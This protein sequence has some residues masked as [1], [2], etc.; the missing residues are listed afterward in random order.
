MTDRNKGID[1]SLHGIQGPM[2]RSDFFERWWP[3]TQSLDLVKGSMKQVAEAVDATVSRFV[4]A[5]PL[6]KGWSRYA[7]LD[8]AFSA[9][10]EF[11]GVPT[12]FLLLPTHSD[13]VVLWTNSFLCDGYD[14]LCHLLTENYGLTTM[15]WSAHDSTTTFQPATTFTHRA[16]AQSGLVER[17]VYASQVDGKWIFGEIGAALPE[18]DVER[19]TARKK[20]DR[21]NESLMVDLLGRMGAEPWKE[22]YY[23]LPQQE[24]WTL[25]R[26]AA[27][28]TVTRRPLASVVGATCE[29]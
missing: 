7:D 25:K 6:E 9:A 21:L 3:A 19:Y 8:Q 2:L 16:M 20:A 5:E 11:A 17:S 14:S 1:N 26:V 27:P 28:K 23:A 13:W 22:T 10:R 12:H 15:H 24:C 18:E 29:P 4:P